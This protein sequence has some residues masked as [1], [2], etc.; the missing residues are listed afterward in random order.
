MVNGMQIP[1]F[2]PSPFAIHLLSLLCFPICHLLWGLG[3][4]LQVLKC[5]LLLSVAGCKS[6]YSGD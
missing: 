6:I 4:Y 1:A 5:L 3:E 2:L